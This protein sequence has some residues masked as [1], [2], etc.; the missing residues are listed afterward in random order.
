M[1]FLFKSLY[2]IYL[3]FIQLYDLNNEYYKKII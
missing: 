3:Y 2:N 1:I